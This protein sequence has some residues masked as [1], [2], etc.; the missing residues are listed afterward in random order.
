MHC[1]TPHPAN[2][3][4]PPAPPAVDVSSEAVAA[5]VDNLSTHW[6]ADI[7]RALAADRDRLAK[8]RD[9]AVI[10]KD[11]ALDSGAELLA[12][13]RIAVRRM[14]AEHNFVHPGE[15]VYLAEKIVLERDRHRAFVRSARGI[16][17]AYASANPKH[18]WQGHGPYDPMGAHA[19]L[20]AESAEIGTA[21]DG[22]DPKVEG[23]RER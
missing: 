18:F 5:H 15:I 7:L 13:V 4:D 22:G 2:P 8:E 21:R 12:K 20:V 16:V 11:S 14:D 3:A 6:S 9:H 19:W 10:L 1:P 23:K 17:Q